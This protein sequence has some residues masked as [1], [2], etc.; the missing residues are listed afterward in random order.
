MTTT[1]N[2]GMDERHPQLPSDS[3]HYNEQAV[4]AFLT[5]IIPGTG[6]DLPLDCL[7]ADMVLG[8]HHLSPVMKLSLGQPSLAA[9]RC[10]RRVNDAMKRLHLDHPMRTVFCSLPD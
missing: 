10:R 8:S 5:D 6:N 7:L 9:A 1:H 3:S 4:Q 2:N